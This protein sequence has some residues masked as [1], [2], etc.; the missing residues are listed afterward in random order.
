MK[1]ELCKDAEE[2]ITTP[3][4]VGDFVSFDKKLIH[5]YESK[6]NTNG[7]VQEISDDGICKVLVCDS[8][9]SCN[10]QVVEI[11]VDKLEKDPLFIGYNP[12]DFVPVTPR[13]N[14]VAYDNGS[15]LSIVSTSHRLGDFTVMCDDGKERKMEELNWNP[16]VID[17]DGNRQYY[18]RDFC[19]TLEDKQNLIES[20]YRGVDCGKIVLRKRPFNLVEEELKKGNDGFAFND[21]VDGKQRLNALIGFVNSE[22]PDKSG[23]FYKDFSTF[24]KRQFENRLNF[25]LAQLDER[26]TDEDVLKIFMLVNFAGKEMSKEHLDYVDSILKKM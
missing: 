16:Y 6:G 1:R 25:T 2:Y 3:V 13:L 18:Q 20:I 9:C 10:R 15:L 14:L 17:K 7:K 26:T 21:I 12:F 8:G 22:F 4:K 24:G 5:K 23:K 19:W 11:P